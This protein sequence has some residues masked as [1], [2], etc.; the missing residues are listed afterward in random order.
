MPEAIFH[1]IVQYSRRLGRIPASIYVLGYAALILAFS[2][3][4]SLYV[5]LPPEHH[6]WYS[7]PPAVQ[8][9]RDLE[10]SILRDLRTQLR[11]A[12]RDNGQA[13]Q[14]INGWRILTDRLDVAY[15]Y[16]N[17]PLAFGFQMVVPVDNGTEGNPATGAFVSETIMVYTEGRYVL[18]DVV[19]LP[20]VTENI[21]TSPVAGIPTEIPG[22]G[23]HVTVEMKPLP[24][25][26]PGPLGEPATPGQDVLPLSQDLYNRIL[27]LGAAWAATP[28]ASAYTRNGDYSQMLRVSAR[29]ASLLP[30]EEIRPASPLA[31]ITVWSER[32]LAA[33]LIGLFLNSLGY[34]ISR[35]R[36]V[37]GEGETAHSAPK[38]GSRRPAKRSVKSPRSAAAKQREVEKKAPAG[39]SFRQ[40]ISLLLRRGC[41]AVIAG[42]LVLL[43]LAALYA[44]GSFLWELGQYL[45]VRSRPY[46]PPTPYATPAAAVPITTG[47][48]TP[49]PTFRLGTAGSVNTPLIYG[50]PYSFSTAFT[51]RTPSPAATSTPTIDYARLGLPSP[52]HTAAPDYASLASHYLTPPTPTATPSRPTW[53]PEPTPRDPLAGIVARKLPAGGQQT[54]PPVLAAWNSGDWLLEP[55]AQANLQAITDLVNFTDGDRDLFLK[56]VESWSTPDRYYSIGAVWLLRDDFDGDGQP[57]VLASTLA[58]LDS[59]EMPCCERF[60]MLFDR[61]GGVYRPVHLDT[62]FEF[63]AYT[64]LLLEQ[65]LN[66]D[67]YLEVVWRTVSCGTACGQSLVIG[68]WDGRAWT[69]HYIQ[70]VYTNQNQ[71][72]FL[73]VDGDGKTEVLLSYVTAYKLDSAYPVRQ[74]ID[75]YGWR[76]GEPVLVEELRQPTTN[77]YGIMRDT[78]SALSFGKVDEAIQLARPALLTLGQK[79]GPIESYTAIE[80][81]LA[82]AAQDQPGAMQSV[83]SNIVE[84]CNQPDN[85]FVQAANV[86]WQAYQQAHEPAVA[87]DAMRRFIL[88]TARKSTES[89]KGLKFFDPSVYLPGGYYAVCPLP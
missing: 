29:A 26:V 15:F 77:P 69:G 73:D 54:A 68:T 42:A 43:T 59:K 70:S 16:S 47:T 66:R 25:G 39:P 40:S 41:I 89:G 56:Y 74:A 32:L 46:I 9:D 36:M 53:T 58:Y 28:S 5:H 31:L 24:S 81:M 7:A 27:D 8:Q 88:D 76:N 48:V 33:I 63:H 79:C 65:D 52:T 44:G 83:L 87:C 19:Y 57:E 62:Q 21:S 60:I 34:D 50:T 80:L 3:L 1:R 17:L 51:L 11:Q 18:N 10:A 6:F 75:I 64:D 55:S 35:A 30:V 14:V 12:Y 85:G 67:G 86:L 20:F 71:V 38:G 78:Y 82:Y 4:Y 72:S 45:E 37:Q 2:L 22:P 61:A 13:G 49:L 23:M 84:H